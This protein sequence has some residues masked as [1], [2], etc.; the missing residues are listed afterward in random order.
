MKPVAKKKKQRPWSEVEA[1]LESAAKAE[2]KLW[3]ELAKERGKAA[4]AVL[5]LQNPEVKALAH[6]IVRRLVRGSEGVVRIV[7]DVGKPGDAIAV[8]VDQKY[9]EWDMLWRVCEI[10]KD[11]LLAVD[12]QVGSYTL[13]P[14]L[15]I[16]CGV[17][18]KGKKS[19]KNSKPKK[20]V[21]K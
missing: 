9:I 20:K 6:R 13:P 11:L 12:I 4:E 3:K 10:L 19:K 1:E 17:P 7:P 8:K 21:K 5:D 14:D 2:I 18:V 15:C 16:E